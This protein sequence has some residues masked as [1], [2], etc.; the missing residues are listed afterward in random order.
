[1]VAVA[2]GAGEEGVGFGVGVEGFG[3]GI[4]GEGA[5]ELGGKAGEVTDGGGALGRFGVGGDGTAGLDGVDKIAEVMFGDEELGVGV[6]EFGAQ[7]VE[8]AGF[9]GF[10][11]GENPAFGADEFGA[12]GGFV[13]GGEEGDARSAVVLEF[14]VVLLGGV[15][16]A[17]VAAGDFGGVNVGGGG[18]VHSGAP[19]A[20]V[21]EVRAPVGDVAGRVV[22]DP[23]EVE[24]A[25]GGGVGSVGGAAEPLG[26]VEVGGDGFGFF[27]A[28]EAAADGEGAGDAEL[29][30]F[31]FANVAVA[32]EFAGHANFH[33]GSTPGAAL[34]DALVFLHGVA[35]GAA[36]GNAGSEGFF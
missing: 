5:V 9:E 8:V 6:F 26:V 27:L 22:V 2:H 3:L 12:V 25:A 1:M 20:N 31:E 10:V 18:V 36:F 33:V 23:A 17:G 14:D 21:G 28:G 30:F 32:D 34:E 13:V 29:D 15:V 16:K 4:V 11:F 24:V 19:L 7:D 35:D